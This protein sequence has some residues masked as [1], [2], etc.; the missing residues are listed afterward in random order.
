MPNASDDDDAPIV[1]RDPS[2]GLEAH[3]VR[4][5]ASLQR[6]LVPVRNSDAAAG[7]ADGAAPATTTTLRDVVLGYD[8]P[9]DYLTVDPTC[10]LGAVVGRV[11]NR[12][13]QAR[14]RIGEKDFA[15]AANN[16]PNALHGGTRGLDRRR[17]TLVAGGDGRSATLRYVSPAGEEGYPGTL[18][19]EARYRIPSGGRAALRL[20]MRARCVVD[21]G[22]ADAAMALPPE[23][24]PVALAAHSYFN[25]A[26]FVESDP[27]SVLGFEAGTDGKGE[28]AAAPPPTLLHMPRAT[29]YTRLGAH[30]IPTGEV[31][32][33]AGTPFDFAS[34][35]RPLGQSAAEADPQ[36]DRP[37]YDHNFVVATKSEATAPG[38]VLPLVGEPL[39]L[40]ASLSCGTLQ[41]DVRSNAPGVQ[42]YTG[43][44]LGGDDGRGDP[45]A[46][47]SKGGAPPYRRWSG[48]CLETQ[49]WPDA[50][51][52]PGV[53]PSPLLKPGEEY[54]HVVEYSFC[55][56]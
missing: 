15:L 24:T 5:G 4:A 37:G 50:V 16:G 44:Y 23:G 6:L 21:D 1:L 11:A 28:G 29:H 9:S 47:R 42:L 10:Y 25:L 43:N 38:G 40:V 14:F 33:V 41:M 17:W 22:A 18:E 53:F 19:V 3:I 55:S 52:R 27:F 46:P 48:V 34:A 36:C 31:L 13:A 32:P 12:I 51:N 35:P 7:A 2:T 39:P 56:V 26:G 8:K 20:E 54:V 49:N 45:A 30:Q